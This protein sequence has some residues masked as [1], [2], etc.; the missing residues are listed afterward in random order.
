MLGKI[1]D[2]V[3][4]YLSGERVNVNYLSESEPS[5]AVMSVGDAE[6]R[7]YLAG[8]ALR[9]FTFDIWCIAPFGDDA[10]V[11]MSVIEKMRELSKKLEEYED[12]SFAFFAID[13]DIPPVLSHVGMSMAKYKMRMSVTY[14]V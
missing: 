5:Y 14:S 9:Q 10:K 13:T 12:D 8:S 11:N 4:L 6:L 7:K 1:F 3:S 2:I